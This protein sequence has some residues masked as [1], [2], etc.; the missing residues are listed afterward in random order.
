ML[1]RGGDF[2]RRPSGAI[3]TFIRVRQSRSLD[4]FDKTKKRGGAFLLFRQNDDAEAVQKQEPKMASA[5]FFSRRIW[6]GQNDRL[7][8]RFLPFSPSAAAPRNV[9]PCSKR[10]GQRDR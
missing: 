8:A 10:S 3:T 4:Q 1:L 9:T 7:V 6:S 5:G 2:Y